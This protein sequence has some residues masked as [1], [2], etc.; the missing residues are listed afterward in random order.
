MCVCGE[1]EGTTMHIEKGFIV[2]GS[3]EARCF[4]SYYSLCD[5]T[6]RQAERQAE[7]QAAAAVA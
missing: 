3:L 5:A 6:G 4:G 7:R 2:A 1:I